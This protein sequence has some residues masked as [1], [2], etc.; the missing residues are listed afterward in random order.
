MA[1]INDLLT[2]A[3]NAH[4]VLD[5]MGAIRGEEPRK[6]APRA[7]KVASGIWGKGDELAVKSDTMHRP[8]DHQDMLY[9]QWHWLFDPEPGNPQQWIESIFYR[10]EFFTFI[11]NMGKVVDPKEIGEEV[12]TIRL[13]V[14]GN[15]ADAKDW[16]KETK[17]T[18]KIMSDLGINGTRELIDQMIMRLRQAAGLAHEKD[19]AGNIPHEPAFM[20]L[21]AADRE[22][23]YAKVYAFYRASP[24]PCYKVGERDWF[25]WLKTRYGLSQEAINKVKKFVKEDKRFRE[26]WEAISKKADAADAALARSSQKLRD[27]RK[28]KTGAYA[29]RS[30][31]TFDR[32]NPFN[33][34]R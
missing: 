13:G 23:A 3:S 1:G 12:T 8:H 31:R 2:Y 4:L 26:Y 15:P 29:W 5:V 7:F 10:N 9:G 19:S 30:I 18:K 11:M 34:L 20:D 14:G 33:L 28:N 32:L 17:T 27:D 21:S 22:A 6:D 25:D 24:V 16:H